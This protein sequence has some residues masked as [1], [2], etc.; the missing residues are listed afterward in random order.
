MIAL[1]KGVSALS[2]AIRWFTTSDYSHAAWI[3]LDGSLWE[4]W[5]HGIRHNP[6]PWTDHEDI[7]E[8]DVFNFTPAPLT[9]TER[10]AVAGAFGKID[11][12]PYDYE[13]L[14]GFILHADLQADARWT[15]SEALETCLRA[16][17]RTTQTRCWPYQIPPGW[18]GRSPALAKIVTLHGDRRRRGPGVA[19]EDP[20]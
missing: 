16:A 12:Q 1:Y 13:A 14:L 2:R 6:D 17:G 10:A 19:G 18:I 3:N 4:S 15:C 7:T 8:I 9:L 11:K 20:V 5:V